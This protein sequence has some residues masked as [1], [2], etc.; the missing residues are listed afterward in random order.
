MNAEH[1]FGASQN[2]D[3]PDNIGLENQ[4]S[5]DKEGGDKKDNN[6][7]DSDVSTAKRQA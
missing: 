2:G 5:E 7:P 1:R 4:S 6:I 3:T